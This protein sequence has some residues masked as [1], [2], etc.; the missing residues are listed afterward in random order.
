MDSKTEAS[1]DH[2]R[3]NSRALKTEVERKF[4]VPKLP[5]LTGLKSEEILQGYI[6]TSS[7]CAEVRVR[8]K[9]DKYFETI[10]GDG[11]LK[12][13]EIEVEISKEQYDSLWIATEGRRLQKTRYQIPYESLTIEIDVYSGD[14]AGLVVAEVEF[15]SEEESALFTPPSWFGQEVTT[16]RAFRNKN[17]AKKGRPSR[18]KGSPDSTNKSK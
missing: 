10:K 1:G 14:L 7:D 6:S 17:L 18:A 13:S 9:G 15:V 3:D 11:G 2:S 12:R 16:D 8:Q 5:E 4:L